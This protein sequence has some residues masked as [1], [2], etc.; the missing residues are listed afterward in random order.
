MKDATKKW[1]SSH[2]SGQFKVK[3]TPF[4]WA[5]TSSFSSDQCIVYFFHHHLINKEFDVISFTNGYTDELAIKTKN[6]WILAVYFPQG[7]GNFFAVENP[8][9]RTT[10]IRRSSDPPP[11]QQTP[12]V[13]EELT[14]ALRTSLSL[15]L[16]TRHLRLDPRTADTTTS[17]QHMLHNMLGQYAL[18]ERGR[19]WNMYRMINISDSYESLATVYCVVLITS[20]EWCFNTSFSLGEVL[21]YIVLKQA[22]L[23]SNN[24]F[25]LVVNH[26]QVLINLCL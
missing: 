11:L 22:Y 17:R 26:R 16:K 23:L 9:E 19:T 20:C 12:T 10:V 6:E 8:L 24:V 1:T 2:T 3:Y 15:L 21:F 7:V 13:S 14:S 25:D 4:Q 5:R 18:Y